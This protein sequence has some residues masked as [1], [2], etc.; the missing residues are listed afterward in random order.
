MKEHRVGAWIQPL[1]LVL[2]WGAVCTTCLL[3]LP[4][5]MAVELFGDRHFQDGI[6]VDDPA[7]VR[8]GEIRYTKFFG[9][10]SWNIGQWGSVESIYGTEPTELPSGAMQWKNQYKT[11]VMG[12]VGRSGGDLVLAVDSIAEYGGVYRQGSDPWPH[13]LIAQRTSAPGGQFVGESPSIDELNEL[14]LDVELFLEHATNLYT[15]GYNPGIHAAQFLLY[16]TVQNLNEGYLPGY[17]D[18]LWFGLAFYDD[19]NPL[20]N[21]YFAGDAS[22]GKLI[23]NI[24]ATPYWNTGLQTGEWKRATVDVLPHIKLALQEAWSR[25][26]LPDSSNPSDYKLG[27]MNMGW[28]VPGLSDVAMH[29]RNLSLQAYGPEFSKPDEFD[30]DGETGGWQPINV[31]DVNSGS[32]NGIWI[33]ETGGDEPIL[34]GPEIRMSADRYKQVVMR[35]A[36]MGNPSI[37][38]WAQL[39]WRRS[40]DASFSESRSASVSVSNDGIYQK[41]TFDMASNS[42][43]NGEIVQLRLDPIAFGNGHPFGI[44]YIRPMVDFV[45]TEEASFS[46]NFSGGDGVLFWKGSPYQQYTLQQSTNLID[47]S[48]MDVPGFVS[49][50]FSDSLMQWSLSD[51]NR[52]SAGFYHLQTTP[53][54]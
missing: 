32:L 6:W 11:L 31:T 52:P 29:V 37:H 4:P 13:L 18:Y 19:R 27:G 36:N 17:G 26:F 38:S 5:T 42:E 3:T 1:R 8:E 33:M 22:T 41:Y 12:P 44:D 35:M 2:L 43:W 50:P 10:P 46:G 23:Y 54:P 45:A 28:E 47:G 21:S 15:E 30:V 14:V 7:G 16:L 48:W 39:F 40:G 34:V 20:P 9:V 49:I 24:G 25:G 53:G 51:S